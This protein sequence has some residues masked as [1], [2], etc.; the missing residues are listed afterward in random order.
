MLADEPFPVWPDPSWDSYIASA[1]PGRPPLL[2]PMVNPG[3]IN[4]GGV[5][6]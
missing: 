4:V 5:R 6:C 1:D 3:Y 2:G